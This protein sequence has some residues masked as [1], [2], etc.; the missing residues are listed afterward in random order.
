MNSQDR[1]TRAS[2]HPTAERR[3]SRVAEVAA[4]LDVHPS[5]IYRDIAAGRLRAL[6][7]GSKK[8]ALRIMPEDLDAYV[9]LLEVRSQEQAG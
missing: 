6:R 3:P 9:A 2:A 8:G 5:T 4:L 7:V 1:S